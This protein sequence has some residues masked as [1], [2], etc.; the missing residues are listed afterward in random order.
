[1]EERQ[2]NRSK[3]LL[4]C[5]VVIAMASGASASWISLTDNVPL[6]SL[7][8]GSLSFGDKEFSEFVLSGL[9]SGGA[10]EPNLNQM[11]I[12][13]VQDVATGDYGLRFDMHSWNA[14]SD[15][16]VNVNLS[17][18]ASILPGYDDYF[19]KD[20][21]LYITGA[22]ATGTGLVEAGENVWDSFPGGTIVASL[23][24]SKQDGDNGAYLADFAEFTPLKEIWIQ[25]KYM[26]LTGGTG[27]TAHLSEFFQFYSQIPEPAT[28]VLLGIGG[29]VIMVRKRRSV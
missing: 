25:T 23:S 2:M 28:V 20:I 18:K 1:M 24:C 5:L 9:A 4:S 15:Q 21:W 29:L 11:T 13:G 7:D 16:T 14:G 17:F 12:Q 27:G 3:V 19:I 10:V 8:G 6:S 26:S 22:G